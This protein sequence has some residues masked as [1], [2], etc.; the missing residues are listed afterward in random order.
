MWPYISIINVLQRD[1]KWACPSCHSNRLRATCVWLHPSASHSV[2][3]CPPNNTTINELG[4]NSCSC[5][6]E[7]RGRVGGG[8]VIFV[9]R[10]LCKGLWWM[11]ESTKLSL[12]CFPAVADT[13]VF[14]CQ[15]KLIN[16]RTKSEKLNN[17]F[18]PHSVYPWCIWSVVWKVFV[19]PFLY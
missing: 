7:F 8:G 2:W 16:R 17:F 9:F 5:G 3:P 1:Y 18:P 13:V 6:D 15:I 11:G 14:K 12:P 4:F 10:C 19:H